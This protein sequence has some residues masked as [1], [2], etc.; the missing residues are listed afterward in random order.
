MS[1]VVTRTGWPP[2]CSPVLA[3]ESDPAGLTASESCPIRVPAYR[4]GKAT[5]RLTG[6]YQPK[7][8]GHE[9]SAHAAPGRPGGRPN[10]IGQRTRDGTAAV[11]VSG[12]RPGSHR[13]TDRLRPARPGNPEAVA[14]A[15]CRRSGTPAPAQ[16]AA[17]SAGSGT[18]APGPRHPALLAICPRSSSCRPGHRPTA[19]PAGATVAIRAATRTDRVCPGDTGRRSG[20]PTGS[21]AVSPRP[22]ASG[23]CR[24]PARE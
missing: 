12:R 23:P 4:T 1:E 24:T 16:L 6:D 8:G 22:S 15:R 9:A 21:P 11:I 14:A 17:H 2:A 18:P 7:P 19:Q 3:S 10:L 13:P 5:G 20:T